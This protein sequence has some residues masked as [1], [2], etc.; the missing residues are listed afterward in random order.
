MASYEEEMKNP[1]RNLM[2]GDLARTLLIQVGCWA[3]WAWWPGL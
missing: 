3:P 2:Y 1:I